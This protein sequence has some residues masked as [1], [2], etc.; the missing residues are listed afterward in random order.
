MNHRARK[1]AIGNNDVAPPAQNHVGLVDPPDALKNLGQL[2]GLADFHVSARR[3]A[4]FIGRKIFKRDVFIN[5]YSHIHWVI[6]A[7]SG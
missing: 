7:P 6:S 4:D 3:A 2:L 5:F 1:A